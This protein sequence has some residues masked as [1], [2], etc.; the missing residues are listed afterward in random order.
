LQQEWSEFTPSQ[1][2]HCVRL[3]TTGGMPSYVELLTCVEMSKAS[4]ELPKGSSAA[5]PIERGAVGAA[6]KP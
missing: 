2:S 6:A 4:A 3:S 5:K 1:R